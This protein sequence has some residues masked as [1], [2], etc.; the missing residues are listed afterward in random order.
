[1]THE[2]DLSFLGKGDCQA[3]LYH[4][5]QEARTAARVENGTP[6]NKAG[7]PG[8]FVGKFSKSKECTK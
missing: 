6:V 1:M 4:D 3:A 5:G 2:L 8:G 7:K